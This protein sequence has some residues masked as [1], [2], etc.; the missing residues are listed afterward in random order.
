MD[1]LF[2][3][4][5]PQGGA[6]SWARQHGSEEVAGQLLKRTV[7][8]QHSV[9]GKYVKEGT[10]VFTTGPCLPHGTSVLGGQGEYYSGLAECSCQELETG[11]V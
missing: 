3:A 5:C 8:Q 9:L 4:G 6:Q 1:H 11:R 2:Y 7:S 10:T